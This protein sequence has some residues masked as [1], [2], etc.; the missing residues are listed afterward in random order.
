MPV[1]KNQAFGDIVSEIMNSYKK[2]KKI[3]SSKPGT[4]SK[5]RQTA[6]AIAF[7]IKGKG[8]KKVKKTEV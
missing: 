6:L 7:D 2:N 8:K 5:A 4:K 1:D 3:G